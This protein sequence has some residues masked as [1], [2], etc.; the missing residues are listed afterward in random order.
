MKFKRAKFIELSAKNG[1]PIACTIL[2]KIYQQGKIVEKNKK[3]V[4]YWRE[5]AKNKKVFKDQTILLERK[6]QALKQRLYHQELLKN[7]QANYL[8]AE[9]KEKRTPKKQIAAKKIIP[10]DLQNYILLKQWF[11]DRK[12]A[13]ILPSPNNQCRSI[14]KKITCLSNELDNQFY[15]YKIKSIIKKFNSET[16]KLTIFSKKRITKITV[17]NLLDPS[18]R[19]GWIDKIDQ[20]NCQLINKKRLDCQHNEQKITFKT[21]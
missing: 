8:K 18:L 21:K 1:Y 9:K 16:N 13:K 15:K 12:F 20:Y 7:K 6:F 17:N 4:T 5:K 2:A 10:I 14:K 11:I 3:M 19:K